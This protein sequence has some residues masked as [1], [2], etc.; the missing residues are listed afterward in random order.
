MTIES[1]LLCESLYTPADL[2]PIV[3]KVAA[4]LCQF[5][6]YRTRNSKIE[7]EGERWLVL[8]A[9]AIA[10]KLRCSVRTVQR[11]IACLREHD[12]IHTRR[13]FA[14]RY[15]Q[16]L[17]YRPNYEALE[18]ILNQEPKPAPCIENSIPPKCQ[19]QD[20]QNVTP[21]TAILAESINK[22]LNISNKEQQRFLEKSDDGDPNPPIHPV[23]VFRRLI[24]GDGRIPRPIARGLKI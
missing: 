5:I 2:I 12:L 8:S 4:S 7:A 14:H 15:N 10:E 3:G 24:R 17:G 23:S 11:S 13:I 19:N 18:R 6:H 16:T 20:R 1:K 21:E 9:E 22:N